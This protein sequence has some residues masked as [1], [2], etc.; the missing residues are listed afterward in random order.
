M[1]TK[2]GP[3]VIEYNCRFGDPETQVVLPL[4]DT[5]LFEIMQAVEAE[6]LSEIDVKFKDASACCVI[7]ASNGYPGKY[8]TGFE[9]TLPENP[10]HG[11][12]I[13]CAGVKAADGKIV[14]GGG[15]VLGVTA[16]AADLKSAITN[17]YEAASE[18][19]FE[20]A[21]MRSD[22]GARALSAIKGE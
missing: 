11:A 16:I 2:N 13:F 17:A 7:L 21:Y 18:I 12:D 3:K 9:I 19:K 15:R 4:L 22:I 1:I 10:K 14:T 8:A 20:N 6:T 5:D